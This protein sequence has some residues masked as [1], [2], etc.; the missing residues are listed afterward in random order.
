MTARPKKKSMKIVP[1]G[2]KKCV[3]MEAGVVSYKL[4]DNNFDCSTCVYD[5]GMQLKVGRQKEAAGKAQVEVSSDT[6]TQSWVDKMMELPA[7][8]R[9]CRYMITGEISR[10]ICPNSYECG[11][12]SFDQMMQERQLAETLPVHAQVQ[13]AGFDLAEDN[14]YHEGHAWA[15]L[16][17]SHELL[18]RDLLQVSLP[19]VLHLPL[20]NS[21]FLYDLLLIPEVLGSDSNFPSECPQ[22]L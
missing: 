14:Y 15:F 21:Q 1:P 18:V 12:C 9:K 17:L 19:S 10:K 20:I 6:F 8:Q 11:N 7:S 2:K 22:F 4:C 5:Q 13:I 3:W 16:N